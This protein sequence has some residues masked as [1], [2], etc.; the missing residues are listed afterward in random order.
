[1]FFYNY[2][3]LQSVCQDKLSMLN[4]VDDVINSCS[5]PKELPETIT[6]LSG[7]EKTH[8]K[9]HETFPALKFKILPRKTNT[10]CKSQ[11]VGRR[12]I[13]LFLEEKK[14]KA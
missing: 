7:F 14:K 4:S 1:M 12:K 6:C 2:Y 9:S 13:L 11:H 3:F 10:V 8:Q 5:I